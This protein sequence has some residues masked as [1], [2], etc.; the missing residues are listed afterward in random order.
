MKYYDNEDVIIYADA[1]V[2]SMCGMDF[3]SS[4]RFGSVFKNK[5]R[6]FGSD[7]GSGR[8]YKK[9]RFGS[10]SQVFANKT[11]TCRFLKCFTCYLGSK[12]LYSSVMK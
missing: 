5:P 4:G 7:F 3:S 2:L 11:C 8:F 12:S 9:P 6:G 10:E 1:N